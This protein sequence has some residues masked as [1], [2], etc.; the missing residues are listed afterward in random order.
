M[1][2]WTRLYAAQVIAGSGSRER[3]RRR[4][5]C[6]SAANL[7]KEGNDISRSNVSKAL[8]VRLL[9]DNVVGKSQVASL[10]KTCTT[11]PLF[12]GK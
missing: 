9:L 11:A 7:V 1:V 2:D 4:Q 3:G 5:W 12:Q 10:A 8:H 6:R